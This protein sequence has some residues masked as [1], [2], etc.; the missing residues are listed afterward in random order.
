MRAKLEEGGGK[1]KIRFELQTEDYLPRADGGPACGCGLGNGIA[2]LAL[3]RRGDEKY[4]RLMH[5]IRLPILFLR[6]I[7]ALAT[8]GGP[9]AHA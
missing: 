4:I 6:L 3:D 8:G 5:Q 9:P 2:G 7:T 1:V